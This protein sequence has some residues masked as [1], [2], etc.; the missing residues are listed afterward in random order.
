MNAN[1]LTITIEATQRSLAQRLDEATHATGQAHPR[2]RY[3][4][5]DAFLAATSRHLAAVDEA[6]LG[7]AAH[8][9]QDGAAK[10]KGYLHQARAL[11]HASALLKARLYGE[12]HATYVP[13]AEVW[14]VVRRELRRHNE[15]ERALAADLVASLG[16]DEADALADLLYHAEVKAPTRAHPYIP[17]YGVLGHLARRLWAVA[18]RF[19]DAAEGRVVPQPV[20]PP[21]KAHRH[22]SLL[23]Q[24]LVGEPM[25]DAEAPLI[26]HRR[27]HG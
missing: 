2:D 15:L 13:W 27:R 1:R 19:W 12:V 17:H 14:S 20:R 21:S 11:E 16:H 18:D 24:Y 7:V 26:S 4:R 22:D 6:L 9:L 5:T 10:V 3:A 8:R 25:L 23:A